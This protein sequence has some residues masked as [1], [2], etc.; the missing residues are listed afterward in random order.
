V[1]WRAAHGVGGRHKVWSRAA[2]RA[3]GRWMGG[4]EGLSGATAGG[5]GTT[6]KGRSSAASV[7]VSWRERDRANK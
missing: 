1:R 7:Y 2:R 3:K 5:V 6:E 4:E